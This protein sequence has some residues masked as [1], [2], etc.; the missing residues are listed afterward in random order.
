MKTIS[1]KKRLK[2]GKKEKSYIKIIRRENKLILIL[3]IM[4]K[5]K[6]QVQK[7]IRAFR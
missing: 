1:G 7:S 6:N 2:N 5:I 4:V 3:K